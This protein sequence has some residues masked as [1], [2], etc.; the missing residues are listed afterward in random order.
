MLP[1]KMFFYWSVYNVCSF[2]SDEY[3]SLSL[4][5]FMFVCVCLC[6][7]VCVI[8]ANIRKW[9]GI[10]LHFVQ[11]QV[12]LN[13]LLIAWNNDKLNNL[14]SFAAKWKIIWL[15]FSSYKF[16]VKPFMFDYFL[17]F[18]LSKK[19]KS[20]KSF[21]NQYYGQTWPHRCNNI[22]MTN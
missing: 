3:L 22:S 8:L 15:F 21:E 14:D 2:H 7:C 17:A 6:V 9:I 19:L 5:L 11:H 18:F 1:I 12:W 20:T 4:S 16:P 13:G 10:A